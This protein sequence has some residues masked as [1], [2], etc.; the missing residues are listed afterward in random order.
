[1]VCK[2]YEQGGER[3]FFSRYS[4]QS[5]DMVI[6]FRFSS[7]KIS[8]QSG[9]GEDCVEMIF[10]LAEIWDFSTPFYAQKAAIIA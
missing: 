3:M 7:L 8:F 10:I 6:D 2:S 1:M 4:C 5:S 9:S